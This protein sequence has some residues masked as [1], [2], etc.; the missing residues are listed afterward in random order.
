[1][2]STISTVNQSLVDDQVVKALRYILPFLKSFSFGVGEGR[3]YIQSDVVY[4]PIATDPTVGSKTAGTMVTAS[5]TLAGTAVTLSNFYGASWDA[6]EGTMPPRVFPNYWADKAAG[7]IYGLAKQVVDAALALITASNFG[8]TA[9]DKLIVAPG[10][11]GQ[12]DLAE[13]WRL[14]EVKIKQR[15]RSLGLNAA[16][17]SAL[18]GESN[19]ALVFSNTGNN[20]VANGVLPNPI[21]GMNAWAYGAFPANSQA[22]G[23]AVIGQ[24]ALLVGVA[25]PAPLMAAGDGDIIERRIITDPESGIAVLY[26][27][28]GGGGGNVQGECSLLYGVAKGQDAVVRLVSE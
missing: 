7:A 23:G 8:N 25:A 5:G 15:V 27:M 19:L 28:K 6:T 16:Y 12:G 11:F 13:L 2:A 22:L 24:A 17:S 14:A 20:F 10:D 1:M 3:D 21:I 18:L 9:A 4:V 26:T